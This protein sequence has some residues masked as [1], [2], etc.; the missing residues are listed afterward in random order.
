M[1]SMAAF[2][3]GQGGVVQGARLEALGRGLVLGAE[4]VRLEL[5][6]EP[7]PRVEDPHVGPVELVGR[8]QEV[9][10]V[11][12]G[13]VDREVRRVVHGVEHEDGAHGPRESARHR[14]VVHGAERVRGEAHGHDVGA[15]P[16]LGRHVFVVETP[17]RAQPD[18]LHVHAALA[19]ADPGAAV[20]FVVELG[21]HDLVARGQLA[22]QGVAERVAER[23][24]VLT[25]R[26]R[27]P[28]GRA[29]EGGRRLAAAAISAS[30]SRLVANWPCVFALQVR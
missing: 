28:V 30:D 24:H 11:E 1:Y 8:A 19:Q 7:R 9:I 22:P 14:R 26:D 6:E 23:R 3:P 27:A 10:G 16:D 2:T 15:R 13:D 5:L 17:V 4:A 29:Q 18:L 21:D 20:G 25:E 12:S